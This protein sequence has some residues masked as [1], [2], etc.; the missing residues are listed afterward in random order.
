M[1]PDIK[2]TLPIIFVLWCVAAVMLN[3]PT[4]LAYPAMWL[5]V[6]IG[7]WA[8]DRALGASR[9]TPT[10]SGDEKLG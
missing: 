1:L 2:I 10:A 5:V 7:F 3:G 6:G 8:L 9:R 4:M